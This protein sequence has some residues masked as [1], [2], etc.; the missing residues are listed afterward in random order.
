LLRALAPV[1]ALRLDAPPAVGA[2]PLEDGGEEATDEAEDEDAMEVVERD[3]RPWVGLE[4]PLELAR[5]RAFLG[6]PAVEEEAPGAAAA[7]GLRLSLVM[8]TISRR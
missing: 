3:D 6:A 4:G 8:T 5:E 7:V 1:D 2:A